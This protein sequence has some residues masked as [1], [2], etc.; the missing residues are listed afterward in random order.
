LAPPEVHADRTRVRAG[1]TVTFTFV[2]PW[3]SDLAPSSPFGAWGWVAQGPGSSHPIA[4]C[5]RELFCTFVVGGRGVMRA[6]FVADGLVDASAQSPTIEVARLLEVVAEPATVASGG[7]V[8]F[9]ARRK[10]G[11]PVTVTQWEWVPE[12]SAGPTAEPCAPGSATCE[13]RLTN[14]TSGDAAVAQ[15]GTMY[16]HATVDGVPEVAGAEVVVDASSPPGLRLECSRDNVIRG[17]TV[18]CT[19]TTEPVDGELT[20]SRWRF[21]AFDSV[22]GSVERD[23][24]EASEATWSGRI[25][26]SGVVLVEGRINGQVAEA[27]DTLVVSPRDWRQQVV[28]HAIHESSP[29]D[30]P[31]PPTDFSWLGRTVFQ[32]FVTASFEPVQG[33]PN[34]GYVY[35]TQ[36]PFR[37]DVEIKI[38]TASLA[39]DSPF[40]RNQPVENTRVGDIVVCGQSAV[41]GIVPHLYAHEGRN[42]EPGSHVAIYLQVFE[43]RARLYESRVVSS[44]GPALDL[45]KDAASFHGDALQAS[46]AMDRSPL[47]R[48][49]MRQLFGCDDFD[50]NVSPGR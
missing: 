50:Y 11:K 39:E 44:Q 49:N 6:S 37:I 12:T 27:A 9:V 47:N 1:D 18:A 2:V 14:T 34:D 19:V 24:S 38:N 20:L 48:L 23:P 33:G 28:E 29:G 8:R 42:G 22:L 4:G 15:R 36:L 32:P 17:E 7:T 30:L 3:T 41:T 31:V 5:D 35:F 21:V 45:S 10:D 40:W 16:A 25:V 43:E 46:D 26:T 13:T